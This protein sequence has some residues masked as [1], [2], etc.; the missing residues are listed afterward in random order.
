MEQLGFFIIPGVQGKGPSEL[1]AGTCRQTWQHLC[2]LHCCPQGLLLLGSVQA[3]QALSPHSPW[4]CHLG[5]GLG[6]AASPKQASLG[7]S[8]IVMAGKACRVALEVYKE[9]RRNSQ[10]KL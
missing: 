9:I 1:A 6:L 2:A 4:F 5:A 7:E 10:P 8:R 3:A